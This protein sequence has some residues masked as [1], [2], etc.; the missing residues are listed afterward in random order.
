MSFL[1]SH[2]QNGRRIA[3]L[4]PFRAIYLSPLLLERTYGFR[5]VTEGISRVAKDKG[6]TLVWSVRGDEHGT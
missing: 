1:F 6:F 3:L 2:R 5:G 4:N